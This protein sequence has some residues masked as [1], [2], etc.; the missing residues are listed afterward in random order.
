MIFFFPLKTRQII[1]KLPERKCISTKN[2]NN[3]RAVRLLSWE[4]KVDVE[5]YQVGDVAIGLS[6]TIKDNHGNNTVLS[7][8]CYY[9]CIWE[10]ATCNLCAY[11]SNFKKGLQH[12]REPCIM[13]IETAGPVES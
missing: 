6:W 10:G 12:L 8:H 1:C 5:L 4:N 2:T 11:V 7:R 9:C 13:A 3:L